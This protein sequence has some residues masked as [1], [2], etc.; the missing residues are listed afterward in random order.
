MKVFRTGLAAL[1]I[2]SLTSP[3]FAGDLQ[4]SAAKAVE[5]QA[6][7]VAPPA[8]AGGGSKPL[9]LAG[10]AIFVTGF[11]VGAYSFINNKNGTYTEF[12][13]ATARNVKLGSA[14]LGAAFAGGL[15]MFMGSRMK[16]A[17]AVAAGPGSLSLTKHVSW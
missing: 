16:H 2:A 6:A 5:N 1:L 14:G 10:A 12:G 3:A 4:S 11:T 8:M 13:E 17:P 9:V 7:A 15:I